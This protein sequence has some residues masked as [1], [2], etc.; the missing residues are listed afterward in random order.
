MQ[1]KEK[2]MCEAIP[3]ANTEQSFRI[4]KAKPKRPAS[5]SNPRNAAAFDRRQQQGVSPNDC[6]DQYRN[7]RSIRRRTTPKHAQ[8]NCG[9]QLRCARKAD[10]ANTSQRRVS[11]DNCR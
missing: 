10:Q 2:R 8:D 4:Q 7:K 9:Q 1:R 6:A 3:I 11:S 5:D